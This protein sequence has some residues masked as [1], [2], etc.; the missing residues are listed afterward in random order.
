MAQ[1]IPMDKTGVKRLV[2]RATKLKENK[3][4]HSSTSMK[5]NKIDENRSV[6]FRDIRYGG[7]DCMVEVETDDEN[8]IVD[9][10][11]VA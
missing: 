7:T 6:A 9:V 8:N 10:Y 11:L 1:H 5:W 2:D 4:F 3:F